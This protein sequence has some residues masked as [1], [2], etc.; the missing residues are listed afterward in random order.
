MRETRGMI[1]KFRGL[2]PAKKYFTAW[3]DIS[4]NDVGTTAITPRMSV[5]QAKR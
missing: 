1:N 5:A 3:D 4:L 2:E